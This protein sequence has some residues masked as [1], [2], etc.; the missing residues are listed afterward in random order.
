M[1]NALGILTINQAISSCI[2]I[3]TSILIGPPIANFDAI[4]LAEKAIN[5][6]L[7][8]LQET[9]VLQEANHISIEQLLNLMKKH[10]HTVKDV[11]NEDIQNTVLGSIE[12]SSSGANLENTKDHEDIVPHPTHHEALAAVSTLQRYVQD[13][14]T[15]YAQDFKP[16]LVSFGHQTW[17]NGFKIV[18]ETKISDFFVQKS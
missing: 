7:D 1:P 15:P 13:I 4:L 18:Q 5:K 14:D 3:L 10:S 8:K 6:S 12:K 9:G 2:F 16:T 17:L 11:S